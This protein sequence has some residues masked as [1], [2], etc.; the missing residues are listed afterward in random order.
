MLVMM[1]LGCSVPTSQ[2]RLVRCTYHFLLY[3]LDK[4][5]EANER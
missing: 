2:V 4:W 5:I 1:E 3:M